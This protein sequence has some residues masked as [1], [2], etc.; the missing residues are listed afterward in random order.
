MLKYF[1]I[2][3][4]PDT[5]LSYEE[6]KPKKDKACKHNIRAINLVLSLQLF[7]MYSI[8]LSIIIIYT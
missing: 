2:K 5:R 4:Y 8:W 3:E 6:W 1:K 7:C